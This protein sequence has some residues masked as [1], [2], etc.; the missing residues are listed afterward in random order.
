MSC[1][2]TF[3]VPFFSFIIYFDVFQTTGTSKNEST[4]NQMSRILSPKSTSPP[5]L[6]KIYKALRCIQCRNFNA[7]VN[8][9]FNSE[10]EIRK[11]NVT[12]NKNMHVSFIFLTI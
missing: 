4:T 12:V 7:Q 5:E 3:D 11:Y 10:E 6:N 2:D 1:S 8:E 9:L